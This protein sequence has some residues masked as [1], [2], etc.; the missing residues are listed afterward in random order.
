MV[1]K[2]ASAYNVQFRGARPIF[3]DTLSLEIA[4]PDSPWLAY[5]QFCQHFLAPLAVMATR[6]VRLN[7]LLRHHIDGF[8]LDLASRLLPV[9]ARL[10]PSLL[11][12]LVFHAASEKRQLRSEAVKPPGTFRM[13]RS[14]L[15]GL[16]EN[17]ERT[18][19]SLRPRT[20]G[21]TRWGNY[22]AETN[23]TPA[24]FEHKRRVVREWVRRVA[25][26]VVWDVGANTGEFSRIAAQEG[27]LVVS[28]DSDPMAVERNYVECRTRSS[29]VLALS[30]DLANP[31]P[32]LGWASHER[33]SFIE[34]GPADLVLALAIVHHLTITGNVPFSDISSFLAATGRNIVV[35]FVPE[36]DSQ[37]RRMVLQKGTAGH[38]Y[39]RARF[40]HDFSKDFDVVQ[41]EVVAE[42]SRVL[43][44]MRRRGH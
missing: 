43:Y 15:L 21:M 23:Y 25:P 11:V 26:R 34:R 20:K 2:D 28:V 5:R 22:Y 12:H 16:L 4:R 42:S 24:G 3:I 8:P 29:N 19:R 7:A 33:S 38:E 41:S 40:E 18:I 31:S 6:D 44:L 1:L 32:A 10:R 36:H 13:P 35:E 14:S 9:R 37:V 39:S 17:L 27:A 30:M